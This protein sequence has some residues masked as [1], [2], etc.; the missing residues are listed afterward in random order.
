MD[1]YTFFVFF[2]VI[3]MPDGEIKSYTKHVIECPTWEAVQQMHVPKVDS[4]EIID[5]GA[6]C[7]EP[8]LPLKM[9]PS[10]DA[11]PSTPPVPLSK[12]QG[13]KGLST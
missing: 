13:N 6:T 8:K 4:G 7:L 9:P 2:S 11:V 5:W 3:V 10:A 1:F 12:P